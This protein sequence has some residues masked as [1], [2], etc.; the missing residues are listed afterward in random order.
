MIQWPLTLNNNRHIM[1]LPL[2][3]VINCTKLCDPGAF[4]SF[5]ILPTFYIPSMWQ[6]NLDLWLLTLK[7]NRHLSLIMLINCTKQ[8]NPGTN[9]S[10]CIYPAYNV[11]FSYYVTIQ[12]WLLTSDFEKYWDLPL[13]M[14]FINCNKLY[15]PGAY[16]LFCI[17]PMISYY[18]TIRPWRLTSDLENQ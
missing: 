13:I 9:G 2:I 5:C 11:S 17:L 3:M 6:Y 12:S 4:S 15:D 10:V 7:N 16:G 1:H 18:V 14:V 8:Y